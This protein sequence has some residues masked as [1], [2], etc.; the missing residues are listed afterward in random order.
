M[1]DIILYIETE[2]KQLLSPNWLT[3]YYAISQRK[4]INRFRLVNHISASTFRI[5]YT[6]SIFVVRT[7]TQSRRARHIKGTLNHIYFIL[8][9][10]RRITWY[11]RK[12]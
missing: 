9:K 8:S 1:Y 6:Q 5:R 10:W 7:C 11:A 12:M 4:A 2:N 3:R